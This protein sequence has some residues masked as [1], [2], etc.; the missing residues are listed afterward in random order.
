MSTQPLSWSIP[1]RRRFLMRWSR[2][3]V[4]AAPLVW[5]W[6]GISPSKCWGSTSLARYLI[7]WLGKA[8]MKPRNTLSAHPRLGVKLF[9]RRGVRAMMTLLPQLPSLTR[10]EERRVGKECKAQ[11]WANEHGYIVYREVRD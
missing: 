7:Q 10:S 3:T 11:S 6:D 2:H 8:P 9:R 4:Q 5:R 1:L